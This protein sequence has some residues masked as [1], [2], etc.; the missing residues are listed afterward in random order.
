MQ[1]S[2]EFGIEGAMERMNFHGQAQTFGDRRAMGQDRTASA[3]AEALP[4]KRSQTQTPSGLLRGVV[5]DA[6]HGGTLA[7]LARSLYLVQHLPSPPD[8]MG[9]ARH[10]GKG[11]ASISGRIGRRRPIGLGGNVRRRQFCLGKKRGL[12]V[13]KTTRGKGTK[14]M[15]VVDGE[16]VPLGSHLESASPHEVTLIEPTLE[17]VAVPRRGRGRPRKNPRRLIYDRVADSDGLRQRLGRR[18]IDLI[19]PHRS[20]RVRSTRQDGRKLRRYRRRWKVERTFAWLGNFRRLVVH[21]D[22]DIRVYRAFFHLACAFITLR[23]F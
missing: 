14:W 7:R 5:M 13:G 23:Q 19:C 2:N 9:G 4:Q 10:L 18:G 15:V 12:C 16:G 3:Q 20:N 8:P 22:R 21:W 1:A 11:L 6:A 17:R